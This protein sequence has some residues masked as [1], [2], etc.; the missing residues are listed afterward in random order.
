MLDTIIL[1][2]KILLKI[3]IEKCRIYRFFK[4]ILKKLKKLEK[5]RKNMKYE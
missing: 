1:I 4:K 5:I 2:E 3:I